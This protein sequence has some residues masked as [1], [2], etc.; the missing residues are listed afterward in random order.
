ME[1]FEN[2]AGFLEHISL[3]MDTDKSESGDAVIDHDPALRQ[4]ARVRHRVPARLGGRPVPAPAHAR[5]PGPRRARGGA[6]P[7]ACRPHA[8]AA[9]RQDLLRH[10][11]AHPRPVVV[12]HPVA[13]PRR[14]A[15][16]A[17]RGDGEQGRL[18]AAL[19]QHRR[20]ALRR[21]DAFRLELRH[22]RLAARAGATRAADGFRAGGRAS[23]E[24]AR[25]RIQL[26]DDATA[27]CAQGLLPPR[28]GRPGRGVASLAAAS[29]AHACRSPSRASWSRNRPARSPP[30]RSATACF[31]RNS[32]TATSPPSTATS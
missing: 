2:L 15:G 29:R 24:D 30:S 18:S 3:V 4:G 20:L 13:L 9:A 26:D 5:R 21:D 7:G 10:Q 16:G 25:R 23:A 28:R 6:P 14:I 1:E 27:G 31:T 8:R 19:R 11:P 32:A 17:R 12:Q 22:A